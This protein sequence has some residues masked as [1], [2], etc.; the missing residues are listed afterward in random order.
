MRTPITLLRPAS[1]ALVA[2]AWLALTPFTTPA[3][4][5]GPPR[6]RG[7]GGGP[8]GGP[9]MGVQADMKLLERFDQNRDKR[10]DASERKAAREFI[11]EENAAGRGPR[12]PGPPGGRRDN[13]SRPAPTPG[14]RL[15]PSE[16]ASFPDKPLFDPSVLRTFFLQFENEDWEKEL[17]DFYRT[18]VEVPAT[19]TVD[20]TTYRDVGV[21]FRGASSFFTVSPGL[22]RSLNLSIDFVHKNQRVHGAKTLNLLNS[23]T[24]PTYLR[25]PLYYH[26]ARQYLPA[27]KANYARVVINGESWGVYVSV[28]QFNADFIRDRFGSPQGARWKVPGSPRGRGSLAYLGDDPA[29]Y[30]QIY[31]LKT[32]DSPKPWADLANLCKVLNQTPP[33]QLEAAL[34]PILDIDG[35]LKFLALENTF[36]NADG[37]WIRSSDYNLFQDP[38]GRFHIIP[39]DANETFRTAE[40][41]GFGGGQPSQGVEL[42]PL[43]GADSIDKPLISK[44]LAVPNLRKRYLGFVRDMATRWLDWSNLEPLAQQWQA[45]ISDDVRTDTHRLYPFEAFTQGVR[46]DTEEQGFRGPRRAISIKSFADQRRAFLLGRTEP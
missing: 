22:K 24:D 6:G 43:T 29:P 31:D 20:G 1:L 17:A 34:N 25:T 12:R 37:Y 41:P 4:P 30:R 7:P 8:G 9:P 39:H 10:L 15:A 36:I 3:Q 23:H 40:G 42:D 28:E 5:S 18:D 44:L 16:V 46:Q 32:K 33:D 13:E 2:G 11:A 38:K 14:P 45:Q 19:L 26:V 35:A 27:H 21:R